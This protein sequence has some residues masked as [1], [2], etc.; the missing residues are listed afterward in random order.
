MI[1]CRNCILYQNHAFVLQLRLYQITSISVNVL[2]TYHD[3]HAPR[4]G[5]S[6]NL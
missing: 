5:Q 3:H 6:S 1:I 4:K 2:H